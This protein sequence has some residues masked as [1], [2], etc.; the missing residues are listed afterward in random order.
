MRSTK[1]FQVVRALM[2]IA[3]GHNHRAQQALDNIKRYQVKEDTA[4]LR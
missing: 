3:A 4:V 1:R 2:Q